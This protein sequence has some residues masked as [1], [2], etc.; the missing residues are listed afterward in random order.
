MAER[1]PG[2]PG[3]GMPVAPIHGVR[4]KGFDMGRLDVL[5]SLARS[6]ARS[7]KAQLR[8]D[9]LQRE[10]AQ[11]LQSLVMPRAELSDAALTIAV[12]GAGG[13]ESATVQLEMGA[14]AVQ[15]RDDRGRDLSVRLVPAECSFAPRGAKEISFRVEPAEQAA[16][17]MVSDVVAALAAAIADAVWG[18]VLRLSTR[19]QVD[20][21]AGDFGAFVHRD[22]NRLTADLRTV[23]AVRA[24][25]SNRVATA[26]LD[27][28]VLDAMQAHP[29]ALKLEVSAYG[30]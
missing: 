13:V 24:T 21:N 9:L 30:L 8:P 12:G 16:A 3:R 17:P 25:A 14:L 11:R 20:G 18:P 5:K 23:A 2:S 22:G 7:A 28:V 6:A 26:L 19:G 29:G 15:L 10:V 1:F 27:A 4:Y